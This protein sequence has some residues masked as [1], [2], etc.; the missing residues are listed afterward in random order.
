MEKPKVATEQASAPDSTAAL[1]AEAQVVFAGGA[2]A[3]R[4]YDRDKMG[5]GYRISGPAI[6]LQVDTTLVM[7]PGWAG[8]VDAY[9]NLLLEWAS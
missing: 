9:V 5:T 2:N 1:M 7:P 3:A 4:L 8:E 6:V